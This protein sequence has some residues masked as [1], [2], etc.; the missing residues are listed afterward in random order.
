M[1]VEVRVAG[2][3]PIDPL[4][5]AKLSGDDIRLVIV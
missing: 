2:V 3:V 4:A 1:G 5:R